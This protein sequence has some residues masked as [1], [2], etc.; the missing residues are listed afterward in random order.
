MVALGYT[1]VYLYRHTSRVKP[2][3][4]RYVYGEGRCSGV[5]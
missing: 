4:V 5:N 2:L 3:R 1:P